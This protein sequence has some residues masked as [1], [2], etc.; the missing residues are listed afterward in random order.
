MMRP[1]VAMLT[2]FGIRDHYVASMKGVVLGLCRSATLV[3]ISHEVPPGDVIAGALLIESCWRDLPPGTVILAVVDPGVGTIRR[4]LAAD[5]G[6]RRFVGPDNGLFGLAWLQ[7]PP[8]RV[9]EIAPLTARRGEG[10]TFEGRDRFAPAAARLANGERLSMLGPR[11]RDV[12]PINLPEVR[13]SS[14]RLGGEVI[15]VDRFGNL[16]TNLRGAG[17]ERWAGSSP[18][19]VRVGRRRIHGL[20]RT[21]A[22]V[23]PGAA[24]ALTGSTGRLEVAVNGGHAGQVLHAHRGTVVIIE[25][26]RSGET[27]YTG[28]SRASRPNRSPSALG[29]GVG[30]GGRA[31]PGRRP[32]RVPD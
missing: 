6:G 17:L 23:V 12:V 8:H 26:T 28:G 1:I 27:A 25:R 30:P 29:D 16:V 32:G 21:Y 4:A 15:A 2:D 10:R 18:V 11:V 7:S 31:D 9:V 20:V 22:D 24:C 19:T 5:A 3:D 13:E 14:S